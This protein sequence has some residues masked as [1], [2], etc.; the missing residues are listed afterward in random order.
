[1]ELIK[2][3]E[4]GEYG[5]EGEVFFGLFEKYIMLLVEDDNLD[6]A[7]KCAIYLNAIPE[8]LVNDL[9][10]ASIRYCNAFLDYIGE[11][12][13]E[14]Q[15]TQDILK[16]IFPSILIVPFPDGVSEPVIHLELNCTWEEEHGMGWIIRG[17]K[18][19][20]VGSFN[21][22]DPM[23]DFSLKDEWNYA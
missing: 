12:T 23:G 9:C 10:E 16:H 1:M 4:N 3:T 20:Y 5:I 8:S 21:G 18:V 14:F 22:E 13:I 15:K 11:P 6:Y 7:Y 2:N 19:L 17:N